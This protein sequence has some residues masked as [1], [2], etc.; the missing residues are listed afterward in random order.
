MKAVQYRADQDCSPPAV[1]QARCMQN[2]R[3]KRGRAFLWTARAIS[4]TCHSVRQA[5]MGTSLFKDIP[6]AQPDWRQWAA[7]QQ[8][9]LP[10]PDSWRWWSRKPE[11]RKV[12]LIRFSTAWG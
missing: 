4:L 11:R 3:T 5:M 12:T 10:L 2:P 9:H 8:L 6:Q 7:P 1:A